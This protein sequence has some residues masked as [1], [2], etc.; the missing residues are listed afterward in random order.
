MKRCIHCG[1][2]YPVGTQSCAE[3]EANFGARASTG[4]KHPDDLT[5]RPKSKARLGALGGLLI[6]GGV[7][8]FRQIGITEASY[9]SMGEEG[10][11]SWATVLAWLMIL[12][13]GG[14]VLAQLA[15]RFDGK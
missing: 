6:F 4:W 12:G 15:K 14:L 3:C 7:V 8:V 10:G 1:K 5:S 9:R 13:G 11:T 2:E